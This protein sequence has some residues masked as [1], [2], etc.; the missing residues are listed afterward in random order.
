MLEAS[1][2][3]INLLEYMKIV[4]LQRIAPGE[5]RV[6]GKAPDFYLNM[7]PPEPG[8]SPCAAPWKHSFMLE[9]FLPEAED[10]FESDDTNAIN[11]GFW[12]EDTLDDPGIPLMALAVKIDDQHLIIIRSAQEDH[13]E[14]S[15][16]LNKARKGL[17]E[18]RHLSNELVFFKNKS[19]IDPLTTLYNQ[20]SFID[21]LESD[22][23]NAGKRQR[24]V[25]LLM[26]DID[27]FKQ[28]NDVYGHLT[29]DAVLSELGML[30][31]NCVRDKDMAVRYGGEEFCILS[32]DITGEQ[33]LAF[34][35]KLLKFIANHNF[36]MDRPITVSIGVTMHKVGDTAQSLISRADK[37]LY[38]AKRNGK[39]QVC[40]ED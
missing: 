1:K 40:F 10:F 24:N 3:P 22:L 2:I 17:I 28:V 30:I 38:R 23:C 37:G 18:R 26:F 32:H 39:N 4:V 25:S 13:V 15:R 11:T 21:V 14:R 20:G 31:K 27:D 5:Y 36:N 29:G 33:A 6:L 12:I 7:F 8:G 34:A 35:N 9:E 16:V 19:A